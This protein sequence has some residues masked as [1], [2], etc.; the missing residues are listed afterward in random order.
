MKGGRFF[1]KYPDSIALDSELNV[2]NRGRILPTSGWE[3][4]WSGILEWMDVPS[5][6]MGEVLP[7]VHRFPA[8]KLTSRTQ[9]F[10]N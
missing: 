7:N 3:T 4:M 2:N 10:E 8:D 5:D 9:V 1:G 6:K